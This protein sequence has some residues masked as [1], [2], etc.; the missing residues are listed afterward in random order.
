MNWGKAFLAGVIGGAVITILMILARLMGMTTMNLEMALGS[1]MTR[2][3]NESTWLLGLVIHLLVS[4]LIAWAYMFGFEYVTHRSNWMMGVG[5]AVLHTI[6]AGLFMGM[7]GSLHPLMTP[8]PATEGLLMAPG[9]FAANFGTITLLAFILLHL[10]YGA[11][12]GA[13]YRVS[14]SPEHPS[15]VAHPA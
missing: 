11:I 4:G 5:F 15:G 12:V 9:Y 3:L 2:N 8:P 10:I 6:I 1:M 7:I 13:F 14:A